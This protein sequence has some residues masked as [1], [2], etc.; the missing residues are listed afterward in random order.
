MSQ[1]KYWCFTLN[2]YSDEELN[3]LLLRLKP[4]C[5]YYVIGREVADSGT[6]HLQGYVEFNRRLR[7]SNAKALLGNR[8]HVEIRKGTPAEAASYCKKDAAFNEYGQISHGQGARTDLKGI[9]TRLDS[10]ANMREIA[11]EYFGDFIR[12]HKGFKE[13]SIL[14]GKRRSLD[15]P[16]EVIVYWGRTGS[17]KTRRVWEDNDPNDIWVYPGGGWFDGYDG[18]SVALFDDFGGSEFKITELL[19]LLDRYPYKVRVKGSHV[20][21]LPQ[22]IYLTSNLDPELWYPNAHPEHRAALTRRFTECSY[23]E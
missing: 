5:S 21:W 11:D 6:P 4:Q 23:F 17:G 20:E 2:N 16:P 9:K 18:Q 12:Y 15:N 19:K 10:G 3:G 14:R 1:S 7:L 8:A 22:R 13:Y